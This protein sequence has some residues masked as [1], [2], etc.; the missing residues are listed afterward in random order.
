MAPAAP[1][2]V[3]ALIQE[4][5]GSIA[6]I[7]TD[8]LFLGHALYCKD[9]RVLLDLHAHTQR[10]FQATPPSPAN[11][12]GEVNRVAP[13]RS[14]TG[15]HKD[16]RFEP[17]NDTTG[18][19]K[20]VFL[21]TPPPPINRQKSTLFLRQQIGPSFY[22]PKAAPRNMF[23][24]PLNDTGRHKREFRKAGAALHDFEG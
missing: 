10:H 11:V 22:I 23:G 3:L 21:K 7:R 15:R 18:R 4:I 19:T 17:L 2:H 24:E 8:S 6:S 9:L 5:E 1:D 12:T 14:N 13:R 16:D 20:R